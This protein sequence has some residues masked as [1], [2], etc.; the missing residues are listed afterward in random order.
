MKSVIAILAIAA[1]MT[2]ALAWAQVDPA[3]PAAR[4]AL[5]SAGPEP[6]PPPK[7]QLYDG[8]YWSILA[9][10]T[11]PHLDRPLP[12]VAAWGT[13]GRLAGRFSSVTQALDVEAGL[14]YS[15]FGGTNASGASASRMELGFH[16]A[17]HPGF[18]LIVFNE[19]LYDVLSGI[20]GFV[21]ASVSAMSVSGASAVAATGEKGNDASDWRPS[22]ACGLGV[23]F[24]VSARNKSSGWWLTTR[25]VLRWT[26]FGAA[27]PD[28]DFGD[29]QVVILLGWRSYD[30]SW[31]R[32][33][34][35]F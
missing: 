7:D 23:D 29:N 31:A 28:R 26:R 4:P 18:P 11:V 25:Y 19:W 22:L 30:N 20:H 13:G 33:P 27:V 17:L 10:I 24:P 8:N 21:G 12:A 15:R 9:G 16:G 2:A 6:A 1:Q 14:E 32:L 35:P 34:R 5:R 3:D